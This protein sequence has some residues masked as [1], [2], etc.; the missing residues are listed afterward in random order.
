M[1]DD[2]HLIESI[3]K[4]RLMSDVSD[5]SLV[6]PPFKSLRSES[7]NAYNLSSMVSLGRRINRSESLYVAPIISDRLVEKAQKQ[8]KGRVDESVH[9]KERGTLRHMIQAGEID[10][11][12]A[13][14]Q[15]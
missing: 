15:E 10:K 2:T 3:G 5:S 8:K 4:D 1:T 12:K 13:F 14:L 9:L 7:F 11:A 6:T